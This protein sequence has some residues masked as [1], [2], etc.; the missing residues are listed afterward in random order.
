MKD[1][2]DFL[3]FRVKALQK[4]NNALQNKI[5]ELQ[6]KIKDYNITITYSKN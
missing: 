1:L 3:N 5:I 2:I 6:A 4:E